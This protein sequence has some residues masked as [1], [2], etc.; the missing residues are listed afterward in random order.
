VHSWP[1]GGVGKFYLCSSYYTN[2]KYQD[3]QN[4]QFGEYNNTGFVDVNS[5]D[6]NYKQ[7]LTSFAD[8]RVLHVSNNEISSAKAGLPAATDR[9]LQP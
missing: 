3:E 9:T 8:G 2:I 6:N 1:S 5:V 7:Y 4:F